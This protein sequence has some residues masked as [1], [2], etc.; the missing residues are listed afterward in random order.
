MREPV[1]RYD[2]NAKDNPTW[3]TAL[4]EGANES[5]LRPAHQSQFMTLMG[6]ASLNPAQAFST[7]SLRTQGPIRRVVSLCIGVDALRNHGRQGLW[8][9]AFAGTTR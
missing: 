8:V 5:G 6:F 1:K 2:A 7:S 9:P 3:T 4:A